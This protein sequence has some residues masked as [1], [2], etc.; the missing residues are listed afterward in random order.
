[1]KR[2]AKFAHRNEWATDDDFNAFADLFA[3]G[4]VLRE[5]QYQK[6]ETVLWQFRDCH[7]LLKRL[8]MTFEIGS[9]RVTMAAS[10]YAFN[11]RDVKN[12]YVAFIRS[13]FKET[14]PVENTRIEIQIGTIH[15]PKTGAI[16][17]YSLKTRNPARKY[18]ILFSRW[19]AIRN[20]G[21]CL[22]LQLYE[23]PS[24]SKA[25]EVAP[26]AC[27]QV[28]EI[29][30]RPNSC[31]AR[32]VEPKGGGEDPPP[33]ATFEGRNQERTANGE[34]A[35]GADCHTRNWRH[36]QESLHKSTCWAP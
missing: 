28:R 5:Y 11:V 32:K 25:F 18:R 4:H 16:S 23:R 3:E 9:E 12:S 20:R 31:Q 22:K 21:T 27:R 30:S 17:S 2:L 8:S 13:P 7:V 1:M 36:V 29:N 33:R 19:L 14:A 35:Q 26:K 34:R 24:D 10:Q 15:R 6:T